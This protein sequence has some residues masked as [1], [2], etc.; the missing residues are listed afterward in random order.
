MFRLLPALSS[1]IL[2]LASVSSWGAGSLVLIDAAPAESTLAL[3][4]SLHAWPDGTNTGRAPLRIWPGFDYYARNGFFASTD[5]S[6]GWNFSPREEFQ[7]GLRLWPQAGRDV[8][9]LPAGLEGFGTRIQPQAFA[10]WQVFPA[11]LLQSGFAYGAARDHQGQQLEFGA[12]TGFPLG[13][14]GLVGLGVA[15]TYANGDFRNSYFGVSPQE[16]V[17]AQMPV[18]VLGAGWQDRSLTLSFEQKFGAHWRLDG[19]VLQSWLLGAAADSPVTEHRVLHA[20]TLSLWY[21][22]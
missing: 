10:N 9:R 13:E 11:L 16:S 14:G 1:T 7:Y 17:R 3:G 19:Q 18:R 12:T 21:Q 8:S 20:A 22:F 6:V 4:L 2:L 15:A 5:N